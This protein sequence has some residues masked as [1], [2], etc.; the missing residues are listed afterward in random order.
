MAVILLTD[1]SRGIGQTVRCGAIG[2]VLAKKVTKPVIFAQ[3]QGLEPFFKGHIGKCIPYI[4]TLS[5][6]ERE[7]LLKDIE[8]HAL[9]SE[10]SVLIED[11]Y[12][13]AWRFPGSISRALVIPPTGF[14]HLEQMRKRFAG[15]IDTWLMADS[16]GSPTWPYNP[17][18][19]KELLNRTDVEILGP[20]YRKTNPGDIKAAREL[21]SHDPGRPVC[22][23][24]MGSNEQHL[25]SD[26]VEKFVQVALL[27][28]V[29]LRS[30]VPGIRCILVKGPLIDSG[31]AIP[32]G[33]EILERVDCLP[34]LVNISFAAVIKPGFNLIWECIAAGTPFF[35]IEEETPGK[36]IGKCIKYLRRHGLYLDSPFKKWLD[37]SFR[38]EYERKCSAIVGKF[39]GVPQMPAFEK[40]V[41]PGAQ[42]KKRGVHIHRD[43][44]SSRSHKRVL[45]VAD[46]GIGIGHVIRSV[47]IAVEMQSLGHDVHLVFESSAAWAEDVIPIPFTLIPKFSHRHPWAARYYNQFEEILNDFD[48]HAVVFDRHVTFKDTISNL[49]SLRFRYRAALSSVPSVDLLAGIL[50]RK[51]VD[52][53][54][55]LHSEKDFQ[56]IYG[57]Q[58][59]QIVNETGV[60]EFAG[61]PVYPKPVPSQPKETVKV[62]TGPFIL[63]I[64]GGGGEH[65]GKH[66]TEMI[67][68]VVN[69]TAQ[70]L[71]EN[72]NLETIFIGGPNFKHYNLIDHK[73]VQCVT[74]AS[75]IIELMK[76]ARA[77]VLRPGFN[78][79]REAYDSARAIVALQTYQYQEATRQ[80]LS[81]L[82]N[83]PAFKVA[84]LDGDS[85]YQTITLLLSQGNDL[86]PPS[87]WQDGLPAIINLLT[88]DHVNEKP[89]TYALEQLN[90]MPC[91]KRLIIRV[92]D[93]AAL[94]EPLDWLLTKLSERNLC[95]SLEIIP[96]HTNIRES[97]L[98]AYDPSQ[99]FFEVSQ[100]GYS[101]LSIQPPGIPPGEFPYDIDKYPYADDII[102]HI[103][104]GRNILVKNFPKTFAG[105]FSAPYDACPTWLPTLWAELGGKFISTIFTRLLRSPIPVVQVTTDIWNW[106]KDRLKSHA[107]IFTSLVSQFARRGQAGLVIHHKKLTEPGDRSDIE[108]LLDTMMDA[109]ITS[110]KLSDRVLNNSPNELTSVSQRSFFQEKPVRI[111]RL[112]NVT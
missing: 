17:S 1:N 33:F 88:Q 67:A 66:D 54:I 40:L 108:T 79:T 7:T 78:L 20:I 41:N 89:L 70:Q 50:E 77:T 90:S 4:N 100:H 72:Q 84:A 94:D 109:G 35:A 80:H 2:D 62:P 102:E 29:R 43:K 87:L 6:R 3:G 92:D 15:Q 97:H 52:K 19:T 106:N 31:L 73:Y 21:I 61:G 76:L 8:N 30:I 34:A 45:F 59:Y 46:N 28:Q 42:S 23:F 60:V 95:A 104:E 13:L 63:F 110:I 86:K 85:V 103:R 12:P 81:L 18:Q 26:Y 27:I 37:E 38:S 93:A 11:T 83:H 10:P 64:I 53:T 36:P 101:H 75:N 99:Q 44:S 96:Y 65:Y 58:V 68:R 74:F 56:T 57:S 16:P 25:D 71:S 107:N 111:K 55:F 9:L 98:K 69:H 22:L 32:P 82:M 24:T 14:S 39:S 105:G 5:K 48:P 47:R 91:E 49:L 51:D 112:T